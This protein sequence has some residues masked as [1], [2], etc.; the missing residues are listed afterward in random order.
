M[1]FKPT[2]CWIRSKN[3]DLMPALVVP[4]GM[5]RKQEPRKEF[6]RY[7]MN[8]ARGIP[9]DKDQNCGIFTMAKFKKVKM[10]G[11]SQSATGQNS[12]YGIIY[13]EKKLICRRFI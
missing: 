8:S 3:L 9:R 7:A 6:F 10:Y 12:I 13:D 11:Y 4:G 2:R 5:K 1:H